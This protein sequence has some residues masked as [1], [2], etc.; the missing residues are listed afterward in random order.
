MVTL[1]LTVNS[2]IWTLVWL[3][4]GGTQNSEFVCFYFLFFTSDY[5]IGQMVKIDPTTLKR[6]ID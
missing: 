2:L 1:Y 6:L 3:A 4:P 5:S